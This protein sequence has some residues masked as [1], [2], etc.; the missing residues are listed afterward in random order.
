MSRERVLLRRE[1]RT[2][3]SKTV[4]AEDLQA[5]L[6]ALEVYGPEPIGFILEVSPGFHDDLPKGWDV[7][8]QRD[9]GPGEHF[10]GP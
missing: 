9:Y 10:S 5:L 1:E 2:R 8:Y 4:D 6:D 3:Y 7:V